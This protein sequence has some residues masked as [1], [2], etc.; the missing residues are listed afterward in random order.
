VY[1]VDVSIPQAGTLVWEDRDK[2]RL[3]NRKLLSLANEPNWYEANG[4]FSC[5]STGSNPDWC[6]LSVESA[7][8]TFASQGTW[9]PYKQEIVALQV[10]PPFAVRRLAHHRSRSIDCPACTNGGYFRQ[11]RVSA[12]WDG[13]RVAFASD[14]GY[15]A[16]TDEYA[17]IYVLDPRCAP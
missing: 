2:Q 5:A 8:D 10:V 11:P 9:R 7:D 1:R 14:F 13:A 15:D 6:Y 3:D 17:D 12:S 16:A 4:H